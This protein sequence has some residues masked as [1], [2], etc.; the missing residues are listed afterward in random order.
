MSFTQD[1]TVNEPAAAR[2]LRNPWLWVGVFAAGVALVGAFALKAERD[3]RLAREEYDKALRDY[4]AAGLP[5]PFAAPK[6]PSPVPTE[7][8]GNLLFAPPFDGL[9]VVKAEPH[10]FFPSPIQPFS[11]NEHA[12]I[13]AKVREVG[14]FKFSSKP[15]DFTGFDPGSHFASRSR[16]SNFIA[17]PKLGESPTQAVIVTLER[18]FPALKALPEIVA[19]HPLVVMPHPDW[20]VEHWAANGLADFPSARATGMVLTSYAG[21]KVLEGDGAPAAAVVSAISRHA[22][23]CRHEAP[24]VF[25][26][27]SHIIMDFS[28]PRLTHLAIREG[29]WS[30]DQLRRAVED[31]GRADSVDALR[32][33]FSTEARDALVFMRKAAENDPAAM[34]VVRG[35]AANGS[36]WSDSFTLLLGE[37]CRWKNATAILRGE[38]GRF[39]VVNVAGQFDR[40][41]LVADYDEQ[42]RRAARPE[43]GTEFTFDVFVGYPS[44]TARAAGVYC[45]VRSARLAC[46]LELHRRARG[47][48]PEKLE[49][50]V[51]EYLP[52]LPVSPWAGGKLEYVATPSGYTL[53]WP[54]ADFYDGGQGGMGE[55][56]IDRSHPGPWEILGEKFELPKRIRWFDT[57][58]VTTSVAAPKDIVWTMPAPKAR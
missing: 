9:A 48:Y 35:F 26:S 5:D 31:L 25:V 32:R 42:T 23:A 54:K 6:S 28:I 22:A 20:P 41:K 50:L 33:A 16:P 43:D 24:I 4:L 13:R 40:A 46:A 53:T 18:E 39:A 47:A 29:V 51:P 10:V 45:R 34:G 12:A 44:V 52:A 3:K 15:G 30:D 14:V 8:E 21:C 27:I 55:L 11:A 36:Y 2:L 56:R 7:A 57:R 17:A 58:T 38:L 49:A 19:K 37:A 1:E